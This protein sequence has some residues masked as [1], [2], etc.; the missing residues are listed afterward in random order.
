MSLSSKTDK[1]M[2]LWVY[3]PICKPDKANSSRQPKRP[4]DSQTFSNPERQC[5]VM[6]KVFE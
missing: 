6:I 5:G 4:S 2:K 1:H 3:V